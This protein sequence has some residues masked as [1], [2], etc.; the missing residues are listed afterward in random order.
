MRPFID[1][2]NRRLNDTVLLSYPQPTFLCRSR[3]FAYHAT[4]A[5]ASVDHE[6]RT[7]LLGFRTCQ[8]RI[9]ECAIE[10][11]APLRLKTNNSVAFSIV[12]NTHA[13]MARHVAAIVEDG[14]S[15]AEAFVIKIKDAGL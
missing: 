6:H 13:K 2:L 4:V 12:N 9:L 15:V 11:G 14:L 8:L 1:A 5:L 3:F 7:A 10:Y